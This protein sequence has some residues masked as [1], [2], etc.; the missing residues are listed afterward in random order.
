MTDDFRRYLEAKRTVDDRALDRRLIEELGGRLADRQDGDDGRIRV[1][2]AGAGIGTMIER[3]IEWEVLPAGEAAYTAVDIE[4]EMTAAVPERLRSWS[5]E[6]AAS[7]TGGDT[8]TIDAGARR[9]EVLPVTAD[10]VDYARRLDREQDLLVGAALLDLLPRAALSTLLSA[11]G[12]GGLYY[13]PLVFDGATR[14]QPA[15]PADRA[16]ERHYHAHMDAK[17]GGTSRA[18]GAALTE[19]RALDGV[20]VLGVA[21]SDWIVRPV[22]GAYPGTEAAFLRYILETIEGAVGQVA[23]D[24]FQETL[25][26][27][28]AARRKHLEAGELVYLTHQ[29]DLLGRVDDPDALPP[30]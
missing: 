11:L 30:E 21:G 25:A 3:F 1:L 2:E 4:P 15:H 5:G 10:A 16:V 14:F 24:R 17:P 18:G 27:W 23:P 7:V 26:D 6:R 22:D 13:F 28:L 29:I 9:V 8:A 12:A 19:L 20:S